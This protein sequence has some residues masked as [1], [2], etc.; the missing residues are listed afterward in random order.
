[1]RLTRYLKRALKQLQ[2]SKI[3]AR[4]T[5]SVASRLSELVSEIERSTAAHQDAARARAIRVSAGGISVRDNLGSY[6]SKLDGDLAIEM[7]ERLEAKAG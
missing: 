5:G 7:L 6:K 3:H 1:M 2:A 4:D